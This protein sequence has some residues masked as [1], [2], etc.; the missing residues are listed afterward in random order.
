ML[1]AIV[2]IAAVLCSI[3]TID[4]A[5]VSL[6]GTV[7]EAGSVAGIPGVKVGLTLLK[8]LST[9]T[10]ADGVFTISG[11]TSILSQTRRSRSHQFIIRNNTIVFSPTCQIVTGKADVFSSSGKRSASIRFNDLSTGKGSM[12]LSGI[13]SGVNIIHI[14]INGESYTQTL[15]SLGKDLFMNNSVPDNSSAGNFTLSKRM[16]SG[17]VDTLVAEKEGYVTARVGIE[18][19]DRQ[20]IEIPLEKSAAAGV[21]TREALQT[22]VDSYIEAQN[23]GDPAKMPLAPDVKYFQ[24]QKSIPAEKSICATALPIAF[25][26]DFFDVD[27]C[28]T[29]SEVIVTEGGHPYVFVTRLK[30][31]NGRISEVNA[32][33]TDKGDWIFNAA[34]YLTKSSV[35][36]KWDTLPVD[37]RCDRRT[38]IDIGN[39][40]LDYL[41]DYSVDTVPWGSP[42][43]R[44]EGGQGY[45]SCSEGIKGL[46]VTVPNRTFVVDLDMGTINAF[47]F[48]GNG[49]DSHILRVANKKIIYVHTL[50]ACGDVTGE[51]F[52]FK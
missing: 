18:A 43:Y 24:N 12:T 26:R 16:T 3:V 50:T 13:S 34:K 1:H 6:S 38:L 47:C 15:V 27:S 48:F 29:F 17:M 4:A 46:D 22:L 25:H 7:R 2:R 23:A 30:C 45:I 35:D 11:P 20:N 5:T 14:V 21:C 28:R 40:Y 51:C 44:L 10:D 36:E 9:T 49:P 33:V 42:C 8:D 41:E 37:Q 32:I 52:G 19:Y 39:I 31:D